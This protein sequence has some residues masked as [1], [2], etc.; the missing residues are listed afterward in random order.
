M[1]ARKDPAG[2][3]RFFVDVGNWIKGTFRECSGM[4]SETELIETKESLKGGHLEYMKVPGALKWE[5]ITLKR[6]VTD[7]MQIWKWRKKVEEGDVQ[8]A[9]TN[10]SVMLYDS[11]N[12]EIARWSFKSGWPQ[13]VSGPTFNATTN[14]IGIEELVIVHEGI[15]R[16]SP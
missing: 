8:G 6:G 12:Q 3:M 7:D 16:G 14:E 11:Q 5:N 13:K 9:R 4:G 2:S 15:E 10:G 1:A